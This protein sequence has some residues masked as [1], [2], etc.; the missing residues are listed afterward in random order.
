MTLVA[1][2][3]ARDEAA[4]IE[5]LLASTADVVDLHVVIDTGST[6]DTVACARQHRHTFVTRRPWIDFGANLTEAVR[7]ASELG[8]WALRLD[9]DMTVDAH[10]DLGAWLDGDAAGDVYDV[11]VHDGDLDYRLPLLTRSGRP[12]RYV[13]ATHESLDVDGAD[14]GGPLVGLD[15][16]HYADGGARDDKHRRDLA[17]LADGVD[18]GEPR[19]T[20]YAAQAHWCLGQVDEAIDLYLRRAGMVDGWEE[21]R[22][23]AAYRAADLAGDVDALLAVWRQRP[24]RA[25][26]LDAARRHVA[27]DGAGD[28][29]LFVERSAYRP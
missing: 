21:E 5:R 26:P 13:G 6:D 15:V 22:W 2:T 28:D 20:Y 11:T 19:A 16:H 1:Y 25:E 14:H 3:I 10:P 8:G 12:W 18:A 29:R 27:A 7:Y 9:A 4:I 17:L 23:H 24:W